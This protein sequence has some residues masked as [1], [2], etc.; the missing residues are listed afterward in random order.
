[1][2]LPSEF[3]PCG[4]EDFIA[5][6]FGTIPVAHA[7]GGLTKVIDGRTGFLYSPNTADTLARLLSALIKKKQTN[8]TA[9]ANIVSCASAY[10]KNEYSWNAVVKNGYLPL[11]R[12]V[13]RSV[14][15]SY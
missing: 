10:V 13:L 6:I 5:Q 12:K 14:K 8:T 3:E 9:F 7:T 15:N 1:M 2:V 4:L 11:Y